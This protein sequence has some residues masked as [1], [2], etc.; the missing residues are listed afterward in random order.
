MRV[1]ATV[2]DETGDVQDAPAGSG[3]REGGLQGRARGKRSVCHGIADAHEILRD[4]AP[5]A[6]VEV[7]DLGVAHL[8]VGQPHRASGGAQR[9]VRPALPECIEDRRA[10]EPHGV[11]RPLGRAAEAVEHDE[12]DRCGHQPS[13]AARAIAAKPR[14]S[15][16]APPTSA[17]STSGCA[18]RAAALSGL[19]E[20]P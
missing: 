11:A 5:G 16:L 13:S 3:R 18:S 12:R 8:P 1:H 4:H 6:D 9:G 14:G 7:P 17:P 10:R 15:R 20:P 2:G 19:T